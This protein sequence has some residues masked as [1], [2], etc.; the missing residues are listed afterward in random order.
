MFGYLS[1]KL[2]DLISSFGKNQKISSQD[3]EKALFAIQETLVNADVPFKLVK[4]LSDKIRLDLADV[5]VDSKINLQDRVQTILFNKILEL[6]GGK[7]SD[8][9]AEQFEFKKK[10]HNFSCRATRSR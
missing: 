2:F 8:E 3:I 5:N 6:L 4:E 9:K 10:K 1:G 7:D